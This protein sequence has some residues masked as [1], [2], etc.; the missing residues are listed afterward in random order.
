MQIKGRRG[1]RRAAI[2]RADTETIQIICP[3][4]EEKG[5]NEESGRRGYTNQGPARTGRRRGQSIERIQIRC[6]SKAGRRRIW[7]TMKRVDAE[8]L[9]IKGQQRE[10]KRDNKDDGISYVNLFVYIIVFIKHIYE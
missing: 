9:Q 4:R 8:T 6:H 1:R 10:D 3:Q 7:V 5:C 2:K